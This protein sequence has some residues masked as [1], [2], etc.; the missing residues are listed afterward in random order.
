MSNITI[1]NVDHGSV[2]MGGNEFVDDTLALAADGEVAEGT[3]LARSSAVATEDKL[4]PYDPVGADGADTPVAVMPH[5]VDGVTGDNFVRP[6]V[7]GTVK[8]QRLVIH[9][10]TAISVTDL[11][12]L[13]QTSIVPVS[14]EQ[15]AELDN[16]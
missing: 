12:A 15:L 16:Q 11:D 14:V 1:T 8:E 7:S 10:G 9:D 6:I 2:G 3:I 13:R 5:A 4:V